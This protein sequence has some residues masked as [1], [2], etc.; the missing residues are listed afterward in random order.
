MKSATLI[1]F[2]LLVTGSLYSE[3]FEIAPIML[4]PKSMERHTETV[5]FLEDFEDGIPTN[6]S[7]EDVTDPGSYWYASSY[8]SYGGEG[9][10][11]RMADPNV[12][13]MGGYLDGWYQVLDTPVISLPAS[14]NLVLTFQQYRFIEEP[15][16]Y[17]SFDGW[18]GFNVRIRLAAEDYEEAVIL[19]DCDPAYNC[20]SL[21]GFG[22]IHGEDADGE[23]GI[24][25]WGGF[26]NWH[27]TQI[28]IPSSYQAQDVIISFAFASDEYTST[29]TNP[30]FTGIFIDEIDVAGVFYSD[31]E[32]TESFNGFTNTAVGGD[33]WHAVSQNGASFIGCYD[34]E[35]GVYNPNM[36][37]YLITDHIN[38]PAAGEIYLDIALQT[39]L[40]DSL[41]PECDYFS[42]EVSYI[43]NG[44]WTNWN[45]ISNPTGNP[46]VPNLVFT[47]SVAEWTMFSEGW[48]GYN[49]LTALAGRQA[50]FRIGFH[51]NG[52]TPDAF[53]LKLDDFQIISVN[54]SNVSPQ[55]HI[56][57]QNDFN[58]ANFPNPFNPSTT[59]SFSLPAEQ[60]VSLQIFNVKGQ[61]VRNFSQKILPAGKNQIFWDGKNNAGQE[62]GSG[63]Y[64]YKV[65]INKE[66]ITKKML[67]MK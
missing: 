5:V 32:T 67:L 37:N 54:P 35:T 43:N 64:Y 53:G 3:L 40:D 10:S 22:N 9:N 18:D 12:G 50:R 23:P 63:I 8:N 4:N 49:D 60:Q 2:I 61:N 29:A 59:I 20:S 47:G 15:G 45:S 1:L 51:T 27:E 33:L 31:A 41:F 57:L 46:N 36:K 21:Y 30:E 42:I 11:W 14:G 48:S 19:T 34:P 28:I 65:R 38:L 13:V 62:A 6:W 26:A 17:Q 16:S 58:L 7:S 39:A 44:F 52:N 55:E 56:A 25:G 66:I 24:P